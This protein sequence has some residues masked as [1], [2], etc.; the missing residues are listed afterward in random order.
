MAGG[1]G[2]PNGGVGLGGNSGGIYLM[3]VG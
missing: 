2:Y 1:P 3:W